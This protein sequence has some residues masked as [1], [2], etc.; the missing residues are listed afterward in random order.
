MPIDGNKEFL[1]CATN[2]AYGTSNTALRENRI[3]ATQTISGSGALRV[4]FEFVKQH[5]AVTPKL[6]LS[7]PSWGNQYAMAGRAKLEY[8]MLRSDHQNSL[9]LMISSIE[10][11]T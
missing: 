1:N 9:I 4:G 7:T 6:Y 10:C 2:L 8:T 3:V 11:R 5:A